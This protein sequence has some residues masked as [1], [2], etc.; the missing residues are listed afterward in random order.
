MHGQKGY[1]AAAHR[2]GSGGNERAMH[3]NQHPVDIK[4]KK[5]RYAF[6]LLVLTILK[7][8]YGFIKVMNKILPEPE[9]CSVVVPCSGVKVN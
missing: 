5:I 6:H 8:L 7:L 4:D 9:L 1:S 2:L 3:V